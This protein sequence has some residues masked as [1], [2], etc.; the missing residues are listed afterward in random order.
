MDDGEDGERIWLLSV[1]FS[2]VRRRVPNLLNPDFNFSTIPE[3]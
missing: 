2:G 3:M 1:M